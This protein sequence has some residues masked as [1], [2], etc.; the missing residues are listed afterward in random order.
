MLVPMESHDFLLVTK[1]NLQRIFHFW[2]TYLKLFVAIAPKRRELGKGL[3]LIGTLLIGT[4]I[5]A[6]HWYQ[7]QRP[8]TLVEVT[9]QH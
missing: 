6:F 1:S 8:R 2:A 5:W 4:H 7:D 3:L 9:V